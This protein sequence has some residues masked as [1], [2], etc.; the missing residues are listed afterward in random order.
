MYLFNFIHSPLTLDIHKKK[1][2]DLVMHFNNVIWSE[3]G[4]EKHW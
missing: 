3:K 1:T 4:I 2:Q